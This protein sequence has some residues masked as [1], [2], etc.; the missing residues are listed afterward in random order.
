MTPI[1]FSAPG[2]GIV[3]FFVENDALPRGITFDSVTNTLIGTPV[4]LGNTTVTV[5]AKDDNGVSIVVLD[6]RVILPIVERQQT[7]AG[8]WTSLIRQY[9]IVNAAQNSVN[10]KVLPSNESILGEF[11]RPEP[12]DSVSASGDPNCVKKC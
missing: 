1:T 9:T 6:F 4:L 7:S 5:Y 12:P 2:T 3:Y 8:A 10:G 11:T